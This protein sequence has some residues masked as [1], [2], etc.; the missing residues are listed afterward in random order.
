MS[1]PYKVLGVSPNATDEEIKSAYRELAR[2]YH[3][4][5]YVNNPLGDLAAEK[6]K[7]INE[8]YDQIQASRKAGHQSGG[9]NT[10]YGA[11]YGGSGRFAD[12]RQMIQRG[13]LGEAEEILEG[14]PTD[15]RD[16]EWYFLKGSVFYSRGWLDQAYSYF[17]RAVAMNP[18]NPEYRAALN[19]MGSQ[20]ATGYSQ[21]APGGYRT[22]Q[23]AGGCSSCDMCSGLI[24]ADCCCECMG[25]DL[26]SCC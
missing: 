10:G 9:Y 1:D 18:G 13:R 16:A 20:R 5:H 24:C 14:T 2:K 22:N 25:G 8:A 4:D 21:S 26:I 7:E 11:G 19:Q 12:V 3:P 17:N 15:T 6:M 23:N